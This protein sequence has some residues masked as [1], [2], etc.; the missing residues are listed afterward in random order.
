MW[1]DTLEA[2]SFICIAKTSV[3]IQ[4]RSFVPHK[5]LNNESDFLAGYINTYTPQVIKMKPYLNKIFTLIYKKHG[6][7]MLELTVK[8][9][10]R[11]MRSEEHIKA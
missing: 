8:Y 1:R 9:K 5:N 3:Y 11:N 6:N 10:T 2:Y 7:K 4:Y